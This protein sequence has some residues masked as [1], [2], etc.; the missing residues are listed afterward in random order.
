MVHSKNCCEIH[1]YFLHVTAFLHAIAMLTE[2]PLQKLKSKE[3][4]EI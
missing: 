2:N 1:A 4:L 3:T